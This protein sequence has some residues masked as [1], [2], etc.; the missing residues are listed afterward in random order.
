MKVLLILSIVIFIPPFSIA[1]YAQNRTLDLSGF[2]KEQMKIEDGNKEI[3]SSKLIKRDNSDVVQISFFEI[4]D[5][6][7]VLYINAKQ[8]WKGSVYQKNNPFTSTGW[9]GFDLNFAFKGSK[10]IATIKLIRQ[11]VYIQFPISQE[12]PLYMIQRYDNIWYVR[13]LKSSINSI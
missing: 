2:A 8:M 1:C 11:K 12:F 13:P 4:F 7:V 6:S 9:C 10:N 5:D 3:D